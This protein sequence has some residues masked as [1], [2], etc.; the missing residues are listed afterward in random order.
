MTPPR[1]LKGE[2][3]NTVT[4]RQREILALVMQ[5]LTNK[6]IA[7]A[8]GIVKHTVDNHLTDVMA[9]MGV[10]SRTELAMLAVTRPKTLA[11]TLA[12]RPVGGRGRMPA[13]GPRPPLG[14]YQRELAALVAEGLSNE[15]IA[16]MLGVTYGAVAKGLARIY[17]RTGIANRTELAVLAVLY[18]GALAGERSDP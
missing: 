6:E 9:R 8:L 16:D 10:T 1:R 7:H 4:Q 18:P 15:E 3:R 14:P 5:G 17:A 12:T 2:I 11:G 13:G